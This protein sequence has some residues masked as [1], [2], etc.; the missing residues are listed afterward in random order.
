MMKM[1]TQNE[2]NKVLENAEEGMCEV[3]RKECDGGCE[4][5]PDCM[6]LKAKDILRQMKEVDCSVN[7]DNA[8]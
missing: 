5:H 3:C 4:R 8:N 7:E 2:L 6:V 1:M